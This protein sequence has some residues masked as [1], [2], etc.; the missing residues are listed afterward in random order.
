MLSARHKKEL[1]KLGEIYDN[2]SNAIGDLYDEAKQDALD[3]MA[4]Q[5]KEN[6]LVFERR[7]LLKENAQ[8]EDK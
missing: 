8:I 5:E 4:L 3:A 2:T 7:N 6:A 1:K